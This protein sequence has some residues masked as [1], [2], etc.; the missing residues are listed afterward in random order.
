MNAPPIRNFVELGPDKQ[1]RLSQPA[2]RWLSDIYS[3]VQYGHAW[4]GNPNGNVTAPV[5]HY[6]VNTLG[7]TNVSLY[8]KTLYSNATGWSNVVTKF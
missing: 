1:P 8:V 6:C 3:V 5:G 2:I 4:A 7:G